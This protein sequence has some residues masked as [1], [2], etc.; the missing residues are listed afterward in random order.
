MGIERCWNGYFYIIAAY[1]G[2]YLDVASAS[3]ANGTNVQVYTGNGTKAQKFK[4]SKIKMVDN[5]NYQI[6]MRQ[7][8]NKALDISGGSYNDNANLQIWDKVN[9]SQQIF[10]VKAVDNM[11]YKIIA[12]H[13]KKY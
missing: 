11:Y 6:V 1:S 5:G 2:L 3:T 8:G 12:K 13:S 7:N 4:F 10:N 9:V